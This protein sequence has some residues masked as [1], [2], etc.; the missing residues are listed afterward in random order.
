MTQFINCIINAERFLIGISAGY[1]C[2]GG[3]YTKKMSV[4]HIFTLTFGGI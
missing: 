4:G 3:Y 1:Y 2:F